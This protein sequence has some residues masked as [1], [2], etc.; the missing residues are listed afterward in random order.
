MSQHTNDRYRHSNVIRAVVPKGYG[1]QQDRK[2][3]S[4]IAVIH[5]ETQDVKLVDVNV[6]G[7]RNVSS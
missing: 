7:K 6:E 2:Y 4:T 5:T 1:A 3:S